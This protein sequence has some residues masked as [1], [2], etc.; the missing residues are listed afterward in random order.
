MYNSGK[1]FFKLTKIVL[2]S[3][4]TETTV[5]PNVVEPSRDLLSVSFGAN[6]EPGITSSS[7]TKNIV[8]EPLSVSTD[9]TCVQDRE[10]KRMGEELAEAKKII[11][12]QKVEL[13]RCLKAID[14]L[15]GGLFSVQE[16]IGR[17]ETERAG[18]H[19]NQAEPNAVE[20]L[21][22]QLKRL[23]RRVDML[24]VEKTH[25][26]RSRATKAK[27]IQTA[28]MTGSLA[29][30]PLPP[31]N[32][33]SSSEYT[34]TLGR[35]VSGAAKSN[36]PVAVTSVESRDVTMGGNLSSNTASENLAQLGRRRGVG[37]ANESSPST[38]VGSSRTV[39]G[40]YMPGETNVFVDK[41]MG[42]PAPPSERPSI[43]ASSQPSFRNAPR[44]SDDTIEVDTQEYLQRTVQADDPED[45]DY[46]P[47]RRSPSPASLRPSDMPASIE[48]QSSLDNILDL[49]TP[50]R[51]R[52]ASD[53]RR[54]RST[55]RSTAL[56]RKSYFENRR[57][58]PEWELDDWEGPREANGTSPYTTPSR[59]RGLSN[60]RRGV[61]GG[62]GSGRAP[63]RQKS[64]TYVAEK[65]RDAE[66]YL[67][68][69][70]GKRDM[71]SAR[72]KK[73][74]GEDSGEEANNAINGTAGVNGITG[75]N[76]TT[77]GNDIN[78]TSAGN[79][80]Q[81]VYDEKH[82]RTMDQIF[83]G[84]RKTKGGILGEQRETFAHALDAVA[85]SQD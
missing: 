53:S 85:N 67:L 10:M 6:S 33:A 21:R 22:S 55:G 59:S 40:S 42:P 3:V 27:P 36:S 71:R 77:G 9:G 44:Y 14:G 80:N 25:E 83:P 12:E 69:A 26:S 68:R 1:C 38:F 13:A 61:S 28:R 70:D 23:E 51:R 32:V 50:L 30:R 75:S 82:E 54:G 39:P 52:K 2:N 76:E 73:P 43:A 47:S 79:T 8:P 7:S 45:E 49:A 63:K 56:S 66:G 17:I 41:L 60:V 35:S 11:N 64:E 78:G 84:R 29:R 19:T 72:Y 74:Q 57:Q 81:P 34:P 37:I 48:I 24:V 65:E 46:D 31:P 18:A 58:T 4:A 62:L 15:K 16:F 5:A 20:D